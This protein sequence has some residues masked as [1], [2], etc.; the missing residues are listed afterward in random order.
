MLHVHFIGSIRWRTSCAKR[1]AAHSCHVRNP[2]DNPIV[3]HPTASRS[4]VE[5]GGATIDI[6]TLFVGTT[7]RRR[8]KLG[9]SVILITVENIVLRTPTILTEIVPCRVFATPKPRCSKL[10]KVTCQSL[11]L[12]SRL[13]YIRYVCSRV[14]ILQNQTS[15][16]SNLR[17]IHDTNP[18]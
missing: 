8:N 10:Q 6:L 12:R 16:S 18:R 11:L 7:K 14:T 13:A 3:H 5:S 4:V 15:G 9:G 1:V 17:C 2:C